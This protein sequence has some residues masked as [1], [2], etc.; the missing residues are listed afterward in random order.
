MKL[1][2]LNKP[3]QTKFVNYLIKV[4]FKGLNLFKLNLEVKVG[5]T[6]A[7]PR[8]NLSQFILNLA[9]FMFFNFT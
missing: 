5:Q 3:I 8:V 4:N 6:K 2:E 9:M 1:L 7:K